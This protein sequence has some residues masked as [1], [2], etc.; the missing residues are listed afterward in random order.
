VYAQK[1]GRPTDMDDYAFDV[2]KVWKNALEEVD[3]LEGCAIKFARNPELYQLA[4]TGE[5]VKK[6]VFVNGAMQ[7][8]LIDI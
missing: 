5:E 2:L 1:K 4:T 6:I 7:T 3:D 8:N